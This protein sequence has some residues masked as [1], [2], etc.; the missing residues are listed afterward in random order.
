VIRLAVGI[1]AYSS[2][3]SAGHMLQAG[4]L[5]WAWAKAGL[6]APLFVTVDTA[7]V[8]KARNLL[9]AKARDAKCDW[10]LMCDADTY[11][12]IPQAIF[13]MIHEGDRRQAAV[14]GAPVKMRKRP[15]YNVSRG[16]KFALVPE[17]EW[18]KQVIAVDRIGTAFTAVNMHWLGDKWPHSPWF[19]FEHLEGLVPET[20][21]EDYWFCGG[22]KQRGGTILADGRFEPVHVEASNEA[23]LLHEMGV[24]TFEAQ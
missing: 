22:V 10:L 17:E 18:R 11:Y 13:Q 14:I 20:V 6:P 23:G 2:R 1:P 12:P 7:G 16:E 8:D 19:K 15:G 21:G 3:V 24:G 9:V 4:Q 5:A